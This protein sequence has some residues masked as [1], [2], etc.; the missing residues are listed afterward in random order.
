MVTSLPTDVSSGPHQQARPAALR[1]LLV[2]R[3]A[4]LAAIG[5]CVLMQWIN[6]DW[7]PPEISVSQYGLGPRGW[8]FTCWTLAL[9]LSV[10]ALTRGGPELGARRARLVYSCF[11]PG[12]IGVVVMG[13]V[14]TDA[15]GLQHSWHARTHQVASIVALLALP[16]GIV[17]AMAWAGRRWRRTALAL[18][19]S[20]AA[21]LLL[22]LASALGVSTLGMNAPRSWAFWQ[23]V[24]VT[25]ELM[26]V[27]VFALAGMTG[28]ESTAASTA[29]R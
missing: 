6:G 8:V 27:A 3:L 9:A 13:I 2:G 26:L 4:T 23:S 20:S 16:V 15:G 21:A 22:V 14:R 19:M 11:V 25:V 5:G 1:W 18:V 29:R 24:A 28:R 17:L 10:L 7:F 12:C